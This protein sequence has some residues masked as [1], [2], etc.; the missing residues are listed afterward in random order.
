MR[1]LGIECLVYAHD[2]I[3][4]MVFCRNVCLYSLLFDVVC[5]LGFFYTKGVAS[6][7]VIVRSFLLDTFAALIKV[8]IG[9]HC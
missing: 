2:I 9:Q 7:T 4:K 3:G 8:V 6:S 5:L 1:N